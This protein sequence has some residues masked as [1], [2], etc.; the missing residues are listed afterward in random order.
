MG[1]GREEERGDPGAVAPEPNRALGR[2][3]V[4]WTTNS[5]D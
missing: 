1:R 5:D 4:I 2:Y 3:V